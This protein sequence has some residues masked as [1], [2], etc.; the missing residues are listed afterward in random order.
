MKISLAHI[1]F[2]TSAS[3]FGFELNKAAHLIKKPNVQLRTPIHA[4]SSNMTSTT[5]KNE[6]ESDSCV[7]FEDHFDTLNFKNW[8]VARD[9][10]QWRTITYNIPGGNWEFQYYTN[11]RSNSFV[12]DG[13]LYIKPTLTSDFL[14]EDALKEG[15]RI[16]L[17]SGS[18]SEDCTD[19]SNFGCERI[20]GAPAGGVYINP[21]QSARLRTINSMSLRYGKVEVRA[22]L[23]VGDWLWPAVWMLPKY[24]A[25]GSWPAS[26]EIDIMESR[27]NVRY[28]YGNISTVLS[29][30]HWGPNPYLNKYSLTQAEVH[31]TNGTFAD[32]FHTFGLE[33]TKEGLRTYVDKQT[34]LEVD[35]DK[36]AWERGM[37][38]EKTTMNP[39]KGGDISAPFDQEF[40][41]Q[42][43]NLA[44][45]GVNGF[46]PDHPSKP[47]NNN[48]PHAPN[49]FYD[50]R[51]KWLPTWGKGNKRALAVDWVKVWSME[52]DMCADK[53]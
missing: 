38:D 41:L 13:I 10:S 33:W 22:R 49:K 42:I 40:Y 26:G 5:Q 20:S 36:T 27:G 50:S 7:I 15:G 47:W 2:L 18:P 9:Y 19:N 39:W 32:N 23:P 46:W 37:F 8:Q 43:I 25:Y 17:Y 45:G 29:T 12:E 31:S 24:S 35:F 34:V 53:K 4:T 1:V 48:D 52:K 14:G 44:V 30:L 11:N 16:A 6:I 51:Q 21:I 3:V 28:P